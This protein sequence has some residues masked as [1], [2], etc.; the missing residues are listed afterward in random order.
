MVPATLALALALALGAGRAAAQGSAAQNMYLEA[1]MYQGFDSSPC[2]RLLTA[3]G[4]V[5]STALSMPSGTLY[6]VLAQSDIDGFVSGAPSG[7]QYAIV[8]PTSLATPDNI[9]ALRGT[10]KLAGVILLVDTALPQAFSPESKCPNC[11]FGLYAGQGNQY[12][13]NPKGTGLSSLSF[14]FPIFS[15]SAISAQSAQNIAAINEALDFNAQR[16]Y[17]KYPLYAMQFDELMFAAQDSATCLRRGNCKPIGGYSIWTTFSTNMTATDNKP[18]VFVASKMDSVAFIHDF[19][20]GGAQRS[21]FVGMLGVIEALSRLP[22]AT[23]MP[24]LPKHVVF[25]AFDA[26]SWAFA[27]SQ[28][29]VMDLSQPFSCRSVNDQPTSGCRITGAACSSPCRPTTDFTRIS[30]SQIESFIELDTL[31]DITRPGGATANYYLH[32]DSLSTKNTNLINNF[33]ATATAPI[34][35]GSQPVAVSISAA[36]ASDSTNARLPPS[37]AMAFLAKRDIPAV[38]LSDYQTEYSNRFFGSEFDDG[39]QWTANNVASICAAANITARGIYKQA[40]GTDANAQAISV[41][42]TLIGQLLD[43]F[44]RNVTCQLLRSIGVGSSTSLFSGY[45]SVYFPDR[46]GFLASVANVQ[47]QTWTSSST[48]G[49]CNSTVP[50]PKSY[51]CISSTCMLSLTRFHQA[52]GTGLDADDSGVFSVVNASAGTWTESDW[53]TSRVRVF[54]APSL[55]YQGMQLGVGLVLTLGTGAFTWF[56]RK[57]LVRRTKRD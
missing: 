32:V 41:N 36:A 6:R 56:M 46:V 7:V 27:G 33:R 11:A 2:P 18:V 5:G 10:G 3:S 12:N 40:G 45:S 13:W 4:A 54:K 16:G 22:A 34:F 15:M 50:C 47:M 57:S 8:M 39:S 29:M 44:T 25:A 21:G 31:G 43:C 17:T 26:E 37:S 38:V 49:F 28:R 20:W 23:A 48:F 51:Q 24:T 52:Y 30:F 35:N 53:N 55:L 42:C 19:S 9:A 1:S 14:D